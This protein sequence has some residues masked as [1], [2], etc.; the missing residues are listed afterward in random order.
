[1]GEYLT[2]LARIF[3]IEEQRSWGPHLRTT[4]TLRRGA[5]RHFVDPSL[6]A[7]ALRAG[8]RRLLADLNYMGY[9]YESLVIRDLR[10]YCQALEGEVLHYRDSDGLEVDA[11][12]AL[13]DG[14]W[15][16]FEVK[17]GAAAVDEAARSLTRFRERIDTQRSGEPAALGV[18]VA[19]GYGYV[20]KDGI[21]VIPIAAL[22]P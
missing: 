6:A 4:H 1:M 13:A 5:K 15:A 22:A 21:H 11:I 8:P 17:L 12:V 9:L 18:V 16:A 10:V 14:R 20:R 7:A 19:T 2:S 3:V